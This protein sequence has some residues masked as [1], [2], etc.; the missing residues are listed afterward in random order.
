MN[1]FLYLLCIFQQIL[2][3]TVYNIFQQ[4]DMFLYFTVNIS[5]DKK[6]TWTCSFGTKVHMDSSLLI[7]QGRSSLTTSNQEPLP[8]LCDTL[9]C[10]LSISTLTSL[11]FTIYF[12]IWNVNFILNYIFFFFFFLY[13]SILVKQ[14]SFHEY[15]IYM[16]TFSL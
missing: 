14:F 16:Q 8:V 5:T 7:S 6:L 9:M 13:S 12:G 3:F 1:T 15:G 10:F 2:F 11:P 4:M